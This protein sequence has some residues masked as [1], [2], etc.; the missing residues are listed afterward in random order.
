MCAVPACV[1]LL[2]TSRVWRRTQPVKV[3][4][5]VQVEAKL[6]TRKVGRRGSVVVVWAGF[7]VGEVGERPAVPLCGLLWV[8]ALGLDGV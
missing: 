4:T 8:G 6:K 2:R 7:C 5:T 3:A 1:P